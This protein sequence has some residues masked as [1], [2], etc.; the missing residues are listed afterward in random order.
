MPLSV[1]ERNLLFYGRAPEHHTPEMRELRQ[2]W[3]LSREERRQQVT[4]LR[5]GEL[6]PSGPLHWMLTEL[7]AR[8]TERAVGHF[9]ATILNERMDR[10]GKVDL[11]D[12][13]ECL[14][15][16]ERT[17]LFERA[18]ERKQQIS[19]AFE[20]GRPLTEQAMTPEAPQPGHRAFGALPR[21]SG[22]FRDYMAGMGA[23]EKQLLNEA[24]RARRAGRERLEGEGHTLSITEAQSLLP[25]RQQQEIRRQ[26]RRMAWTRLIPAETFGKS[27]S[28]E[29]L[30]ISDT[31][32]HLQEHLQEKARIAH[33]AREDFVREQVKLAEARLPA[34]RGPENYFK[35]REE[36]E[37][38]TQSVL[39]RLDPVDAHKL[40]EL[41]RYAALTREELYR[42]FETI[43]LQRRD[44]E[45]A[46]TVGEADR[47]L[48]V[49]RKG[50]GGQ[51]AVD[52]WKEKAE[53]HRP[54]A[55]SVVEMATREISS[56]QAG[57][58]SSGERW[59][60][61]SL[62]D[63]IRPESLTETVSRDLNYDHE[64]QNFD[65]GR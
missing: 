8:K 31:V 6:A 5:D 17:Y 56:D 28:A 42:G 63:T 25:A 59:H 33:Q 38:S 15:P 19:R 39:A 22:A 64:V 65:H 55:G 44:W 29:A 58:I 26:A 37:R 41:D 46:R 54:K 9:Q 14:P 36:Q 49:M 61:D 11:R 30:R 13:Y 47:V 51:E 57:Y 7:E 10:P 35:D 12:L 18:Q 16:H 32:A 40:A 23:I 60:F 62:R 43:D 21:A 24:V 1:K 48:A 27:P 45:L 2:F 52:R 53:E 3:G 34:G 20:P 4:R 50:A